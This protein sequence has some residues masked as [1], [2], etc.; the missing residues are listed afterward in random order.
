MTVSAALHLAML[1]LSSRGCIVAFLSVALQGSCSN[2]SL[3]YREGTN[4]S[5]SKCCC[6]IEH[7]FRRVFL[8]ANNPNIS[9]GAWSLIKPNDLI[10]ALNHN[11][12]STKFERHKYKELVVRNHKGEYSGFRPSFHGSFFCTFFIHAKN[13]PAYSSF[14]T[15]KDAKCLYHFGQLGPTV[16]RD[17]NFS[18]NKSYT[19][20]FWAYLFYRKLLPGATINLVGFTFYENITGWRRWIGHDYGREREY[21]KSHALPIQPR[22]DIITLT[23]SGLTLPGLMSKNKRK[24]WNEEKEEENS[25][26]VPLLRN[27]KVNSSHSKL[28]S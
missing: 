19:T 24:R 23:P 28:G 25:T 11:L 16:T 6:R 21:I 7:N 15:F 12:W 20:G 4:S 2:S 14:S 3:C 22:Q 13:E 27:W 17:V 8:I 26:F 1:S 18:H 5:Y 10:V 9:E